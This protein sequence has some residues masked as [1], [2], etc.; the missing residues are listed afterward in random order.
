MILK[1]MLFLFSS[2]QSQNG[3][4]L[5]IAETKVSSFMTQTCSFLS[6]LSTA[7]YLEICFKD[8]SLQP[9]TK[10]FA[11]I[12]CHCSSVDNSSC[13][14]GSAALN[15]KVLQSSSSPPF[16]P[17][18]NGAKTPRTHLHRSKA[19]KF[20][21]PKAGDAGDTSGSVFLSL[22]VFVVGCRCGRCIRREMQCMQQLVSTISEE[23]TQFSNK[24]MKKWKWFSGSLRGQ[25]YLIISAA[26]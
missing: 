5:F 1:F 23:I 8:W 20:T 11:I 7:I 9:G 2:V 22:R 24:G 19:A 25:Q 12:G 14:R 16:N 4:A 26:I 10:W 15:I 13:V 6:Q 3:R 17:L 21:N 18:E